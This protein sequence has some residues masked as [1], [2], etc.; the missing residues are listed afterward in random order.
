MDLHTTDPEFAERF[1][2]FAF[3]EV[4]NEENQQLQPAARYLAIWR[5]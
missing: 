2:Y 1:E 5:R 4:V 3:N